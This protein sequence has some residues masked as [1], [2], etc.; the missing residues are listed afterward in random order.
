MD[1]QM[2]IFDFLPQEKPQEVKEKPKDKAICT[3]KDNCD[4][5]G[6]GC[7]G[8]VEPCR[9][10]GTFHWDK[11]KCGFSGHS[12][13]KEELWKVADSFDDI[14]C[15]KVCCRGC[16]VKLCGARCNGSQ[17]PAPKNKPM[18]DSPECSKDH[19]KL[20]NRWGDKLEDY[21]S[22]LPKGFACAGCCWYCSEAP[23]HGG[24]CK[25][26]CRRDK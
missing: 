22:D 3:Q 7:G 17:E 18:W 1:G 26:E 8:T 12:C 23:Q 15:P 21:K 13:N 20:C 4:A 19:T 24:K 11:K 2:T 9:F 16:D 14:E 10:G 5:Y 6:F 25:F